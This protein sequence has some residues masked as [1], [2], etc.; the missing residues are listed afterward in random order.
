VT[1]QVIL[2]VTALASTALLITIG[3]P[4]VSWFFRRRN[5]ARAAIK[6]EGGH[7]SPEDVATITRREA[8]R[9]RLAAIQD[10]S[11]EL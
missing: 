9:R 3:D 5:R 2:V 4:L 11:D 8:V 7:R 10:S 1:E 6:E